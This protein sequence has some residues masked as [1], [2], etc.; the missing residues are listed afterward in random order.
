MSDSS[1]NPI[2]FDNIRGMLQDLTAHLD[3]QLTHYRQG[4]RY[5]NVRKSDVRVFTLAS[6]KS[7]TMSHMA[8]DLDVSRQ[9]VHSSVKR[10]I[11]LKVVELIAQ[12]GNSRDKLVA[13]TE[14]GFHARQIAVEQIQRLEKELQLV[15]GAEKLGQ[16]R[17]LLQELVVGLNQTN[18]NQ[19]GVA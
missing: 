6:R 8:R 17:S 7:R 16:F 9:A 12:P 14:R 13:V 5:E 15:L 3:H 10:L 11:D 1:G 2:P 18:I 19:V 4:T